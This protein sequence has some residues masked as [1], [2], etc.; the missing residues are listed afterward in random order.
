MTGQRALADNVMAMVEDGVGW[1]LL[2]QVLLSCRLSHECP[3]IIY[4]EPNKS[5]LIEVVSISEVVPL[6]VVAIGAT[7]VVYEP[8][9]SW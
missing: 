4:Y 7:V 2:L 8:Q 6:V 3:I 5:I 9:L 1:W